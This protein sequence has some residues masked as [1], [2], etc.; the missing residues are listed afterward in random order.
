MPGVTKTWPK[1]PSEWLGLFLHAS[2]VFTNSYHGL[3]YSLYFKK[4]VWTANYGNRITS[5]LRSLG[6]EKCRLDVDANLT[7]RVDYKLCTNKLSEMRETMQSY[8][9]NT[10]AKIEE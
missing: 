4:N 1:D 6:L 5:I 7:N 9:V 3:L 8:I 2:A 10:L